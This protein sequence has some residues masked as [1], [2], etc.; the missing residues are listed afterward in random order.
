MRPSA[1]AAPASDGRLPDSSGGRRG[2][3][4]DRLAAWAALLIA[5][6]S[7]SLSINANLFVAGGTD[8]SGYISAADGWRRAE[9]HRPVPL[10]FWPAWPHTLDST[11]PVGHR[12]GPIRGTEVQVYPFGFPLLLAAATAIGGPLAAHLVAPVMGALLV[13]CTF[14]LGRMVAGNLAGLVAAVLVA[15][16]PITLFQMVDA[17]S[18]VPAAACW[19]GAWLVAV[20]GTLGASA[21][22]GLLAAMAMAMRPNLA[23][24]AIV[25]AAVAYAAASRQPLAANARWWAAATFIGASALGP[26]LVLWSQAAL[27]GSAFTSGYPGQ[28]GFFRLAHVLP[29]AALY[30]RLLAETHTLVPL[31][32]L[33]LVPLVLLRPSAAPLAPTARLMTLSAAAMLLVNYAIYLAYLPF[34]QWPFLRFLLPGL[35]ALFVLYGGLAAYVT[36]LLAMRSRWLAAAVPVAALAIVCHG[37]PLVRYAVNDWRAQTRVRLL[38]HYL[39]AAL[40]ETAVVFSAVH[41]GSVAHY[42]GRDIVRLDLIDPLALDETIDGLARRGRR[43]VFVLDQALEFSAFQQRFAG[44][45]F[46][47]LDWAPRAVFTSGT[48]VWY[49]DAADLPAHRGGERWPIDVLR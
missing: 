35:V 27:Y 3:G 49:L 36:D 2:P 43:P 40:P 47:R 13:L 46:G 4:A 19:A 5:A 29:N 16:S 21:T 41:S 33:V 9:L 44:S 48:S 30:P 22:A 32:G 12:P 15:A 37:L 28:S 42:T 23:P 11:A 31:A 45:R 14:A 7:A 38:G 18:D 8:S 1:G 39:D 17:M 34:D 20:R 6:L 26:L 10:A 25:V 24:L